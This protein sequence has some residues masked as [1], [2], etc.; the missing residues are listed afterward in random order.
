MSQSSDFMEKRIACLFEKRQAILAVPYEDRT[1]ASKLGAE[2]HKKLKIWF[3]PPD[4]D[5]AFF[6]RWNGSSLSSE[7]IL[8]K[9]LGDFQQLME[10]HSLDTSK[11]II[12]DG[13]WHNVPVSNHH[14]KNMS[15]AY[16][17]KPEGGKRG[18]PVGQV[19]NMYSGTSDFYSYRLSGQTLALEAKAKVEVMVHGISDDTERIEMQ[20]EVAQR[21][22]IIYAQSIPC[23]SYPYLKNKKINYAGSRQIAGSILAA[24]PEFQY[25][26]KKLFKENENYLIVP[27]RNEN[28]EIRSLQVIDKIGSIKSFMRGGQKSG[29]MNILGADNLDALIDSNLPF[30]Y[31]EGYATG[32]SFHQATG[33]P[34]I[35]CFD[36]GNL[37][38]VALQI[39]S[40]FAPEIPQYLAIDNDQFYPERA[41]K[42]IKGKFDFDESPQGNSLIQVRSGKGF[43]RTVDA[44]SL[45]C[46]GTWQET[47]SGKYCIELE[48]NESRE[49][50]RHIHVS[51][52]NEKVSQKQINGK[53]SNRGLEAG[54][55]A[56]E[57]I[58]EAGRSPKILTPEFMNL[59]ND[60]TDWNDLHV[61]QGL[62]GI[63]R[64]L[65][66]KYQL[67][68]KKQNISDLTADMLPVKSI[69]R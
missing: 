9:A 59:E 54:L 30:A 66:D 28:N 65:Q 12:A 62:S 47:G 20:N 49:T 22:D 25:E 48:Y 2:W 14:K 69:T 26:N 46:D 44:G 19:K 40:K 4:I 11:E 55:M 57:I 64:L 50:V 67:S 17:F 1:E 52:V 56:C 3:V 38:K 15:G 39:S 34:V 16:Y 21:A 8:Q 29:C 51:I 5:L 37:E 23:T 33:M 41:L 60:P 7:N 27:L 61:Q 6:E 43:Y 13:R 53:F 24:C 32:L 45:V 63:T 10:E 31:V 42:F 18:Q 36:A 58:K 35:V 68:F